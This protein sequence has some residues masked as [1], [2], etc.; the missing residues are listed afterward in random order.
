MAGLRRAREGQAKEAHGRAFLPI[1]FESPSQFGGTSSR[2]S[3]FPPNGMDVFLLRYE[4]AGGRTEDLREWLAEARDREAE[5][6]DLLGREGMYTESLFVEEVDG[7]D[8]LPWYMETEDVARVLEV[9]EAATDDIVAESDDLFEEALVGGFEG[10]V[11]EV[12][13]LM[14][15]AGPDRPSGTIRR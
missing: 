3:A 6:L 7:T 10:A 8:Y 15:A 11:S 14:H 9:Y 13:L 2:G 4:I 12:D 5:I 1:L